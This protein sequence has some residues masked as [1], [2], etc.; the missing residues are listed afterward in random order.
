MN[1]EEASRLLVHEQLQ[2]TYAIA[3]DLPAGHLAVAGDA[4]NVRHVLAD[5]LPFVRADEGD[6]RGIV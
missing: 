4:D 5:E 1:A 2:Q 3:C 6:L